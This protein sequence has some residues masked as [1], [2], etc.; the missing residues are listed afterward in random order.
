MVGKLTRALLLVALGWFAGVGSA[1]L[2]HSR[3]K[4]KFPPPT[5]CHFDA[6]GSVWCP[7]LRAGQGEIM[8]APPQRGFGAD[9]DNP[10]SS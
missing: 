10:L 3:Q 2:M 7:S 5:V 1:T 6:D 9:R 8:V 4:A